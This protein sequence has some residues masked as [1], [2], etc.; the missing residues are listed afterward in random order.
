MGKKHNSLVLREEQVS[1]KSWN[2]AIIHV[3]DNKK[4]DMQGNQQNGEYN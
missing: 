4:A 2:K 1:Q 3:Q